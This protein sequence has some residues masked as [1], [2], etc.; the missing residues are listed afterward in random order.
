MRRV[1]SAS[2]DVVLVDIPAGQSH[3]GAACHR[4]AAPGSAGHC[5]LRHRQHGPTPGDC[6]RHALRRSGVHRAA[7]DHHGFAGSLR[8]PDRRAAQS[9]NGKDRAAKYSP[10]SMPKAVVAPR[11]SRST[12]LW[13]CSRPMAMWRWSTLRPGPRRAAHE[14]E[15][16]VHRGGRHP[17]PAPA[18]QFPAGKLHDAAQRR[19]AVA[20]RRNTRRWLVEPSTAE[21]ARL[22]D[23]LVGHF[24]YVVVDAS[25]PAGRD[26]SA[27]LQSFGKR[28][29]WWHMPTSLR[30]GARPG[31][32]N[33]WA[34]PAAGSECAWC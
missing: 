3:T 33:I 25:S 22:F 14:S 9:R 10:W 6:E 15:A 26:H 16:A 32:S 12:W 28:A 8:A 27:G 17:Q 18:G 31:C 7:H 13:R 30:C 23:M 21:F 5:D 11:P 29:C 34:K 4:I 1:Q 24:R 19:L 2:P 20:G